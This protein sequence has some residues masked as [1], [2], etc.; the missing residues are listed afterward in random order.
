MMLAFVL[1]A[2]AY[3]QRGN[4]ELEQGG[5]GI[6]A[7]VAQFMKENG[8]SGMAVAIV[9][10]PYITR[11]TGHGMSDARRGLLASSNTMF[12]IGQMKDAY[13]AV[14]VM[15]LVEAGKLG[16]DDP[17]ER[18]LPDLPEAW[19]G[20]TVRHLLQHQS[21]LPD[22][23]GAKPRQETKSPLAFEP[24][25]NVAYSAADYRLL[26]RLVA[27][28]SGQDYEEFVR[29][30]QFDRLGL[31]RTFFAGELEKAPQEKVAEGGK[32]RKFLQ[33]AALINPTEP[34][35]GN[36][37]GKETS[38]S[39]GSPAIY[40]SAEDISIWDV[41]L[42]GEIMIKSPELR[43]ILYQPAKLKNGQTVPTSGPWFFPG[44]PGL[45]VVT[46][47]RDGFS[48]LLSRFTD[49]KELVCVTL[50]AN[51]EGLDLTQLARRIAGAYDPKIGPPPQ[52]TGMR[53]QQSP[54]SVS[55]TITRLEG[56][57]RKQGATVMSR[58]DHA[59]AAQ[60]AGLTLPPTEEI[61]FGNPAAGTLL[62]QS[63]RAVAVDLPLRAVAWEENGEVWL[64]AADPVEIAQR[65]G[66]TDREEL[67]LKMRA[68][69]DAALL[70]AV[71][72]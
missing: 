10:A 29:T 9:Q 32:H 36:R 31:R 13:T 6:D 68:G 25:T 48:S 2:T 15:Q 49:A 61:I 23:G 64:V 50:L 3:G 41:G 52:T 54:Y 51:K 44:H 33:E 59:K 70:Q 12:D 69:V 8:V 5:R 17:V 34:A 55:E 14:A 27:H 20:L 35:V 60:E 30:N 45:M 28:A 21:G 67:V 16:L 71:S 38:P 47:G 18:H 37:N 66:I 58:I 22:D 26:E 7:M 42:A 72:P 56:A 53:Q 11:V 1:A 24:G 63:N 57:L 46:G 43:K 40:A 4:P 65:N 19:H 39:S 62:M